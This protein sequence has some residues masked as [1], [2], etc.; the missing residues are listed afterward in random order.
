VISTVAGGEN[1]G[2]PSLQ[3]SFYRLTSIASDPLGRGIFLGAANVNS[4][5]IYFINTSGA[6]V[7]IAGRSVP[8]G[9]VRV[10]AG[11]GDLPDGNNVPA[12]DLSLS[13]IPGL[14]VSTDGGALYFSESS[15]S[16]LRAVNLTNGI[17][18]IVSAS[19]F[20]A[21]KGISAGG[22]GFVYGADATNP[23]RIVRINPNGGST[24]QVPVTA[25]P[26]LLGPTAVEVSGGT[27]FIA[28]SLN[29]RVLELGT[30]G[31]VGI[32]IADIIFGGR[33]GAFGRAGFNNGTAYVANGNAQTVMLLS[34]VDR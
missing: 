12:T 28:D 25:T 2:S 34:G 22:D 31:G 20:T 19:G 17:G 6:T 26:A 16:R 33:S 7:N 3:S 24:T 32:V 27:L 29:S 1:D 11:G 10:I 14:A 23:G 9:I 8:T 5:V 15:P 21:L 13:T 4:N 18:S 30:G